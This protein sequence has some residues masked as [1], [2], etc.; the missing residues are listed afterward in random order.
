METDGVTTGKKRAFIREEKGGKSFLP[1]LTSLKTISV[2]VSEIVGREKKTIEIS[3]S[4]HASN[5]SGVCVL[6]LLAGI[7]KKRKERGPLIPGG[8]MGRPGCTLVS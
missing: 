6:D 2:W 3:I 7:D 1:G 4:H 5:C 8:N